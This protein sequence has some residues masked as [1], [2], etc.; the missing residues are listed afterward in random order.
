MQAQAQVLAEPWKRLLKTKTLETYWGKFHMECY[1]FCQ[2][3]KDYFKI[4]NTT[5]MNH[6]LFTASFFY[7]SISI[8]W[9]QYKYRYKNAILIM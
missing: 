6:T 1:H 3:C 7:G 9:A 2:Q 8:K 4:S 5:R